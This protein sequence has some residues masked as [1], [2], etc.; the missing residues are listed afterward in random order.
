MSLSAQSQDAQCLGHQEAQ[1]SLRQKSVYLSRQDK[2]MP[3]KAK[4]IADYDPGNQT[5]TSKQSMRKRKT[6]M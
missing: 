2:E 4:A 1:M 5:L 6:L 3:E